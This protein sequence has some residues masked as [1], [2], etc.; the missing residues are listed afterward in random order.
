MR[1]NKNERK[2]VCYTNSRKQGTFDEANNSLILDK[3]I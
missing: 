3:L 1:I 2:A